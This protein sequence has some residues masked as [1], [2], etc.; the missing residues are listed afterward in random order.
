MSDHG[1]WEDIDLRRYSDF[2]MHTFLSITNLGMKG[3]VSRVFSYEYFPELISHVICCASE[4]RQ[5]HFFGDMEL[6][7]SGFKAVINDRV[8]ETFQDDKDIKEAYSDICSG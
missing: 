6:R 1:K 2:A 7:S 3:K 4:E 5:E 8:R